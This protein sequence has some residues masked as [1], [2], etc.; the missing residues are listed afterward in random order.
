MYNDWPRYTPRTRLG[1]RTHARGSAQQTERLRPQ[2]QQIIDNS[3]VGEVILQ[4]R[5]SKEVLNARLYPG[6][7]FTARQFSYALMSIKTQG[8]TRDGA[9]NEVCKLI[10]VVMPPEFEGPGCVSATLLL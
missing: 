6:C 10:K 8:S 1:S 9:A 5:W 7:R 4:G 2:L 3:V